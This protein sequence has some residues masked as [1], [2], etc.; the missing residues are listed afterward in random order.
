MGGENKRSST[1]E[2]STEG[3]VHGRRVQKEQYMGREYRR[4]IH[5]CN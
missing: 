1:W 4:F 5:R 3:A 2:K